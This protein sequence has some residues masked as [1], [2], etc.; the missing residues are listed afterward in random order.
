MP[1]ILEYI[2]VINQTVEKLPFNTGM[3]LLLGSYAA[4]YLV[5]LV[6]CI[7]S[8]RVRYADKRPFFHFTCLFSVIAFIL[9]SSQMDFKSALIPTVLFWSVG[10]L[11]YGTLCAFKAPEAEIGMPEFGVSEQVLQV[12]ENRP[13]VSPARSNV[14]LEHAINIVTKL[15]TRELA[16]SDR[17]D[18]EK[19]K[20]TLGGLQDKGNLTAQEGE[21]LNDCFNSLLKYMARYGE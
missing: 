15:L 14:R 21:I 13:E 19:M 1:E 18:L 9:C 20:T 12:R 17:L 2:N 4:V 3:W 6:F 11:L 10:Y 8:A 16:R 7:S 5:A